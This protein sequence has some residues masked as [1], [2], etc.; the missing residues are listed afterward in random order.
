LRIPWFFQ[1]FFLVSIQSIE[2]SLNIF[3]FQNKDI[4][5]KAQNISQCTSFAKATT[6]SFSPFFEVV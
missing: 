4:Q 2:N 3:D 1:F 5:D 6:S